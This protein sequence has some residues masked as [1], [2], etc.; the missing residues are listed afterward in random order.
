MDETI[1]ELAETP[2][3]EG[4]TTGT[5]SVFHPDGEVEI[6]QVQSEEVFGSPS[7]GGSPEAE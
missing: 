2:A 4:Y 1:V 7:E 3:V 5:P 6:T